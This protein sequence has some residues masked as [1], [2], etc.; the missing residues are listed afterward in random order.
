MQLECVDFS[1]PLHSSHS[2][3][4]CSSGSDQL[5][6]SSTVQYLTINH[7]CLCPGDDDTMPDM[8]WTPPPPP[9]SLWTYPQVSISDVAGPMGHTMV[10]I[11][12]H[13]QHVGSADER[14]RLL[15]K[16]GSP[17]SS[18]NSPTL[19]FALLGGNSLVHHR[20]DWCNAVKAAY[21][22]AHQTSWR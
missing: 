13:C 3:P 11:S 15:E 21:Q 10:H 8:P 14:W 2:S 19:Y 20:R 6:D 12:P 4:Q 17:A 9:S 5:H 16:N 1:P 22:F 7:T 18:H